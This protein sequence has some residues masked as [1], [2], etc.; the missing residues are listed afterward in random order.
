MPA[1]DQTASKSSDSKPPRVLDRKNP[2]RKRESVL[3]DDR[4]SGMKTLFATLLCA[5]ILFPV[6]HGCSVSHRHGNDEEDEE[7]FQMLSGE[8]DESACPGKVDKKMRR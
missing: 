1:F 8:P 4:S 7:P 6:G 3:E 2:A 5:L